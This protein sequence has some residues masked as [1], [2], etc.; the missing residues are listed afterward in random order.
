M[1]NEE[2]IARLERNNRRLLAGLVGVTL[3]AGL[4]VVI[5][6]G[7]G[8]GTTPKPDGDA[9]DEVRASRFTLVDENGKT[10]ARLGVDEDGTGLRLYD[11]NGKPRAVLSVDEDGTLLAMSDENG[12]LGPMLVTSKEMTLLNMYDKDAK[13]RVTLGVGE[14][15][16]VLGLRDENG[17][18]VKSVW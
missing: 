7:N 17:K 3:L 4:A 2:R 13:A 8:S 15:G 14:S 9:V 16:P 18:S 6:L 10:R 11:E 12:K 5:Q 1:T